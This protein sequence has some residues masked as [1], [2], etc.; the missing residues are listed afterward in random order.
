M[1]NSNQPI[2]PAGLLLLAVTLLI[3]FSGLLIFLQSCEKTVDKSIKETANNEELTSRRTPNPSP[4]VYFYFTNC[5]RPSVTGNFVAGKP[6][7]ATIKLDYIN[8]PGGSYPAFASSI[9][10]GVRLTTPAGTLKVGSGSIVFSSSGTPVSSGSISI[11]VSIGGSLNCDVLLDV[12][13]APPSG[14]SSDPGAAP[15]STGRVTF[16]YRG[17]QV[18]YATVRARDGKVWLQQNLGSPQVAFKSKDSASFGHYFQ[19]G[20]WDDGHQLK[21]SPSVTGGPS[22]QNPSHIAG[23]NP[24]FIKGSTPT[25]AWWG[26]G[27]AITDTWSGTNPTATNGKDPCVAIGPGWHLPSATEWTNFMFAEAVNDEPS[28]FESTLKLPLSGYKA[29]ASAIVTD[30]FTQHLGYYWSNT[31]A[32]GTTAK[33]FSLDTYRARI[34]V[35]ERGYG[36]S[37]RCVKN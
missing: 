17:Q 31:A 37:C 34:N 3:V 5:P 9:I 10:N 28:A 21:S 26:T 6:A 22:L 35:G 16:T 19:W 13:N 11:P 12:L 23:G 4:P 25:T 1:K 15:G 20:R 2:I 7:T 27:G 30:A 18:T 24:N 33:A 36:F 32:S 29:S 8:S 14:P